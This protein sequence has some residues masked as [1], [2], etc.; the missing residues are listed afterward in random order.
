MC[1]YYSIPEKWK[2]IEKRFKIGTYKRKS[3]LS[4]DG[5]CL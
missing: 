2:F 1:L 5:A 4:S 3:S